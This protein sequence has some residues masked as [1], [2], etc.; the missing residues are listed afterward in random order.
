MLYS[1]DFAGLNLET[2]ITEKNYNLQKKEVN[3]VTDPKYLK[4]LKN[5]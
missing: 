2:S 4:D 1:F 5:I 3:F